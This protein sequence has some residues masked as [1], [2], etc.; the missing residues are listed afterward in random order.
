MKEYKK[1]PDRNAVKYTEA[2]ILVKQRR[3][4]R[5]RLTKIKKITNLLGPVNIKIVVTWTRRSKLWPA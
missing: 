2:Y 4:T 5:T 3:I 1:I